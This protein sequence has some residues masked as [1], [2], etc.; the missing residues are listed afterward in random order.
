MPK[1][2]VVKKNTPSTETL[3][4][5]VKLYQQGKSNSQIRSALRIGNGTIYRALREARVPLR[6]NGQPAEVAVE[7]VG[8]VALAQAAPA[9]ASRSK[10]KRPRRGSLEEA[11]A[12]INRLWAV[13]VEMLCDRLATA[14]T[15]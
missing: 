14:K 5:A 1:Q 10:T 3:A 12:E 15:E 9:Q 11:T 7:K 2:A 6:G 8:A 13:I 4:K